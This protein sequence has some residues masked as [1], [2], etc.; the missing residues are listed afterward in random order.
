VTA[1]DTKERIFMNGQVYSRPRF[2]GSVHGP[3]TRPP[4][5]PDS[6]PYDVSPEPRGY[7]QGSVDV[8]DLRDLLFRPTDTFDIRKPVYRP[9]DKVEVQPLEVSANYTTYTDVLP[10]DIEIKRILED[11]EEEKNPA[12]K[13]DP[14]KLD[15]RE[16]RQ[17]GPYRPGEDVM[18]D[19]FIKSDRSPIA[20]NPEIGK[21]DFLYQYLE[22]NNEVMGPKTQMF[23]RF[24]NPEDGTL[25]NETMARVDPIDKLLLKSLRKGE[26][27][28]PN[29]PRIRKAIIDLEKKI[30]NDGRASSID[31]DLMAEMPRYIRG[32]Y[33][34]G[35]VFGS[36]PPNLDS[37]FMDER[38]K[39][40]FV[41]MTPPPSRGA[42]PQLPGFV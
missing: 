13:L 28:D 12:I 18:R 37:P 36:P 30:Y 2:G 4:F 5:R 1:I 9:K 7:G 16:Y 17:P 25:N 19:R 34:P 20:S 10:G 29:S 32:S 23:N 14:S 21:R 42:G 3:D 26:I 35:G 8:P 41:P 22:Q 31:G 39:R 6:N 15:L 24:A 33:R 27:G 40:G 38:I 11:Y